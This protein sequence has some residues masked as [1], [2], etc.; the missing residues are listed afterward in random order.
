MCVIA[1]GYKWIRFEF[2]DRRGNFSFLFFLFL[3]MRLLLLLLFVSL[4]PPDCER[5]LE[6][7]P[8]KEGERMGGGDILWIDTSRLK[9]TGPTVA[10]CTVESID[11]IKAD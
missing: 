3:F 2:R 6:R 4:L 8:E 11:V 10:S 1:Y 5:S 7:E 9:I